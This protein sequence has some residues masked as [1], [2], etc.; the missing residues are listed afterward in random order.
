MSKYNRGPVRPAPSS[1][2]KSVAQPGLVT[3]LGAPGYSRDSQSE[4]YLLASCNLPG[5]KAF[6][7]G[8]DE[9]V[10]RFRDL[11]RANAVSAPDWTAGLLGWLRGPGNLRLAPVIGAAEYAHARCYPLVSLAP[12]TVSVRQV[13]RSV[14][15]RGDEP[16]EIIA[17]WLANFGRRMP[18]GFKRGVADAVTLLYTEHALLRYDTP[19]AGVRFGDVIE[20]VNPRYLAR[21]YGTGQDALFRYAIERRHGRSNAVSQRLGEIRAAQAILSLPVAERRAYLTS[22]GGAEAIRVA[23]LKWEAVAGWLQGPMDAAAW[24]A[25]IPSMGYMALLRNL[26]GFDR[27]GVHD[28]VATQV[29]IRLANP[30]EVAESRQLPFRYLSAYRA[31][32]SLRWAWPLEQALNLSLGNVPRLDGYTLILTDRSPSMWD[33][34]MS[35]HSDMDWADAAALF[36]AALA[37]RATRATLAEFWADSRVVPFTPGES[38]L[39]LS[40]R[41]TC[42]PSP[43]G[44]DIPRAVARHLRPHH[45]RVVIITDE[46]TA[47]GVLPSN[48]T[49]HFL[50]GK[51]LADS[52]PPTPVNNLIPVTVPLYMWNFG[53]YAAGATPSGGHNRHTLGGLSDQAFHAISVL[54]RGQD[55]PWPWESTGHAAAGGTMTT[56]A[57]GRARD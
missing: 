45:T 2:V 31:V 10:T 30:A 49:E 35:E 16:G 40:E 21:S 56:R 8:T 53:G 15:Q 48:C 36:A 6:H 25:C 23:G 54:E 32:R 20:L 13:V 39:R 24:E 14:L 12:A 33:V 27:A 46:Q 18:H 9:R 1:P 19:E 43:G 38:V 57:P 47:P 55:A 51:V 28:A 5:E 34:K 41:F 29:G 44:T 11:V 50:S 3:A 17:Y 22:P 7:E 52:W 42:R 4:L 37:V 26:A